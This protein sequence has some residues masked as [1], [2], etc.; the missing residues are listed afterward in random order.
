MSKDS[1]ADNS[2]SSFILHPSSLKVLPEFVEVAL[3]LPLRQPFTYR[4][5]LGLRENVKTGAR[6]LVPFGKRQLTGYAVALHVRLSDD[7]EIDQDA[8]KDAI[9][10]IDEDPLIT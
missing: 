2:Y 10:L 7:I 3:P 8:I 1:I 6:L 4:L 5:P 9:E